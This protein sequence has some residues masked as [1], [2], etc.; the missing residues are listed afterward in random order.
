MSTQTTVRLNEDTRRKLVDLEL[1]GFGTQSNV[2]R[3]AID[4]MHQQECKVMAVELVEDNAG[5]LYLGSEG[6]TWYRVDDAG[7]NFDDDAV[8][9]VKD[10]TGDWTV[11]SYNERPQGELIG[12]WVQ[13]A[14]HVV[15][16]P[17]SREPVAGTAG[18]R[19]MGL[20]ARI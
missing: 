3:V 7:G 1:A 13:G 15:M 6:W 12:E 17:S 20:G 4:R 2:M 11:G 19:Y 8:A 10:D 14:L 16:S 5:G 9:Y 18:R